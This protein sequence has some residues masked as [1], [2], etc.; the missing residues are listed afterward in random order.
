MR[1]VEKIGV[2]GAAHARSVTVL[3][4][5]MGPEKQEVTLNTHAVYAGNVAQE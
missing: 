4:F 2:S 1:V 5:K 3:T